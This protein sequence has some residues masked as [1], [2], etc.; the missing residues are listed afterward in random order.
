MVDSGWGRLIAG[1]DLD[2]NWFPEGLALGVLIVNDM[3][4]IG[5]VV[6]RGRALALNWIVVR[7]NFGRR[8]LEARRF[9]R[10]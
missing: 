3:A 4:C 2:T 1:L 8:T 7:V 10:V 9:H 5:D 6:L